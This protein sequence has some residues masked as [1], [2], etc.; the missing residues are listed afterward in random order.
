MA[1]EALSCGAE[2]VL[3]QTE[4]SELHQRVC[5]VVMTALPRLE[6]CN[7]RLHRPIVIGFNDEISPSSIDCF[8]IYHTGKNQ[9]ELLTPE[10]FHSAHLKSDYCSGI[11]ETDHF[12]SIVV[13]EL[14]HA[15][16]DQVPGGTTDYAV[17]Q[18]YIAYA[19][20]LEMMQKPVRDQFLSDIGLST[21]IAA[22][23]IN[24]F[25]LM[26]S[27]SVFAA[28]SWLHFSSSENG[29][30]LVGEII[31]GEQTLWQEPY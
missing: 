16:L 21:P 2:M 17:D 26:F 11:P 25:V 1:A 15:L 19:M 13:H 18:E 29:C 31:R 8:G 14:T 3:V 5:K 4:N 28:S 24:E 12:E 23:R 22:E 10:A 30:D 9:I 20:Q 6:S 27:P 7:L